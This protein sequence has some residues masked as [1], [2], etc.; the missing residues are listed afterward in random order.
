VSATETP[1]AHI[2]RRF[3]DVSQLPAYAYGHRDPLFWGVWMLIAIEGMMFA[4][5]ATSYFYLRGNYSEW[6]PTGV[7]QAPLWLSGTTVAL[8][9]LSSLPMYL[10]YRAAYDGRLRQIQL[11][12]IGVTLISAIAAAVRGYEIAN[13]GY[14][15]NSHAYGSLVWAFYFMHTLHLVAGVVENAVFTALTLR[16]PVEKKHM[17]DVR[18]GAYY[19]WFV[20]V[21]WLVLW[22]I[23][24]GDELLFRNSFIA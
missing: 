8:L 5:L 17:L 23:V 11:G 4:L 19:W 24:Y 13:I 14:Q 18:L 3:L 15:W 12:M 2:G 20:V 6:P 22:A 9:I 16:G 10:A 21:S 7:V 1:G